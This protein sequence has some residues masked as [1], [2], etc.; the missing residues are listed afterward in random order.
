[1]KI[2]LLAAGLL[3]PAPLLAQSSS[4]DSL[5]S[6]ASEDFP[7]EESFDGARLRPGKGAAARVGVGVMKAADAIDKALTP[8]QPFTRPVQRVDLRSLRDQAAHMVRDIR[9]KFLISDG[10]LFLFQKPIT[11]G[12]MTLWQGNYA[13]M[14][15]LKAHRDGDEVS[16]DYAEKAFDGLAMMYRPGYPLTR[17]ILPA[18]YPNLDT[19][20]SRNRTDGKWAWQDDASVDQVSGWLFGVILAEKYLPSRRRE[21]G[22]LLLRFAHGMLANDFSMRNADGSDTR[23][24]NMGK[25]VVSP[26][27]GVLLTMAAL[28]AVAQ[29]SPDGKYRDALEEFA[30]KHQD[31]WGSYASANFL[32]MSKEYNHNIGVLALASAILTEQDPERWLHYARGMVRM[33]RLTENSGNSFFLYM[34]YWALERRPDML[35]WHQDD[36]VIADWLARKP[37]VMSVAKKS[38]LEFQYPACKLAFETLNSERKDLKFVKWPLSGQKTLAQPLP[39]WQRPASDFAWQRSQY[40][41]DDW[42]GAKET[43]AR[44]FT[45]LDFLIAYELGLQTGAIKPAE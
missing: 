20:D 10:R 39:V 34:S 31:V 15:I 25:G 14:N 28:S 6:A 23:F 13:A 29:Q 45:G 26:P 41:L 32:W 42:R 21:A 40:A 37:E 7:L 38:M 22:E 27:P 17:G 2:W 35:A 33:G 9:E 30:A 44:V 43:P 5:E 12:D 11:F 18:G 24:G 8:H 36:R 4:F 3:A 19:M 16:R 1:M